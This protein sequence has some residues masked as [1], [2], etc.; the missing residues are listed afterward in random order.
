M[1]HSEDDSKGKESVLNRI[2]RQLG[3]IGICTLLLLS[4]SAFAGKEPGTVTP[5]GKA[6]FYYLHDFTS[7][8]GQQNEFDISRMYIGAKYQISEEFM[9]RYLTD[10][11]HQPGGGKFE[12]FTKYAYLDWN[13][14]QWNLHAL[15]G[16]QGTN[17]WSVPEK[18]WGYRAIR[19]SPMESFGDFWGGVRGAY[20][21]RLED[22]ADDDPSRAAELGYQRYNFDK[23]ANTKMGSS[24]DMGIGLKW[25]PSGFCY[26]NFMVR[27]GVGYKSAEND[28]YKN[29]Q[30]R[31]GGYFHEKAIHVSAY[32]E[33]EPWMGVDD[34]GESKGYNNIQLDLFAS[35]QKKDLF[36]VGV[37]YNSKTIPGSLEDITASC[38]SAFGNVFIVEKKLKALARYDIYQTGFNDAERPSGDPELETNAGLL[39][40][41]LDWM[42]VKKVHLI[43]N[44]Q[45]LS[46]ENSDIDANN[47][48]YV[49]LWYNL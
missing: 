47:T 13:L 23:G 42:P 9:A 40:I 26:V 14:S 10:I 11:S 3:M 22:W 27:N 21:S 38:I 43:P 16:L 6:Y 29:F 46:F 34:A 36:L 20:D 37:N 32:A 30:L 18:A 45:I 5:E 7:G 17:N 41:G 12:V 35:Y 8:A 1:E 44:V 2:M 15:M 28:M 24:A 33:I 31:T 4:V 25:K 39:I 19:K 49:H 48:F